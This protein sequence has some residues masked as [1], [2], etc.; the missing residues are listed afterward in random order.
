VNA[1]TEAEEIAS[2]LSS[3][4]GICGDNLVSKYQEIANSTHLTVLTNAVPNH[5]YHVDR[6]NPNSNNVCEDKRR[7]II[8]LNPKVNEKYIEASKAELGPIG[9]LK[10]GAFLFNHLSNLDG[11]IANHVNTEKTSFDSCHGHADDHCRYHNHEISK[12]HACA[13]DCVWDECEHIGYMRDGFKIYSHC[14]KGSGFLKSCYTLRDGATGTNAAD[15]YYRSNVDC[16]LDEANGFD[17]TNRGYTDH[18]NNV[19]TGYAYVV[20]DTFPYVMPKYA[21][22]PMPMEKY[23]GAIDKNYNYKCPVGSGTAT[24]ITTPPA[25]SGA[26]PDT[27][28]ASLDS[29]SSSSDSSS[30]SSTN[31]DPGETSVVPE[32]KKIVQNNQ[33]YSYY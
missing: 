15:Y 12:L 11:T 32:V 27:G 4:S 23:N 21:G 9:I 20:S 18:L 2:K 33:G 24:F 8:P 3:C 14:R 30:S 7:L 17:F 10:T 28:S 6:T 31:G 26:L 13:Y 22:T 29:S 5:P 25:S 16:D 1:S 19:I